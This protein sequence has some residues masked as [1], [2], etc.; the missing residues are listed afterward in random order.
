[1]L[2][3]LVP[4]DL[5]RVRFDDGFWAPRI[6]VNRTATLPIEYE[7]CLKTGRIDAFR[8]GWKPGQP[9]PPHVFWDSDVAKWIEAAA[10]SLATHPDPVLEGR[11]DDVI[12]LIASAQQPDGYLNCHFT[13]VEPDHRWTNLRD[14]HELYCAGHLIEAGVAHF[15]ATGKRSL[16]DVVCR[17]ADH[18]HSVF[19][20]TKGKK[21][22]YPGHEEIELA[23]VKLHAATGNGRYLR[24]AKYFVDERGRKPHYFEIEAERRGE[25][26]ERRRRGTGLPYSYSQAHLP[27]R[28]QREVAGHAVR[29][30]YLYA[31]MADLA[32][33]YADRDLL[34]AC[35]ALWD[36]LTLKHM[37]LTAGIGS[38]ASNEGFTSD[39]DLPN[40]SAYAE[41]CAAIGLV[42]W[43]DRMLRLERDARYA[44]VMETALYNGVLS[45]VSLD[46]A[47]FFY[48][49]PLESTGSHHREDWFG[50]A[51]CPPNIARLLASIG[52]YAYSQEPEAV[53]VHLY[54]QGRASLNVGD[55]NVGITQKTHY[56][57]DGRVRLALSPDRPARFTLALRIPGW[58]RGARL[59][60]NGRSVTPARLLR[61]G[62][63]HLER[64]W[65]SGDIVTLDLPMPVE[66]IEANPAVLQDC[67]RVALRRGPVV[68]CLEQADNGPHPGDFIL[69]RAGKFKV[70][71]RPDLLGGIAVITGKARRRQFAGWSGCLYRH[72]DA[73]RESVPFIAIP[74]CV[75]D[76]R[77]A[78]EM[79]VWLLTE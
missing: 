60:I 9:N 25:P 48:V 32:A 44:D 50:C 52:T 24:L 19:G 42:F 79:A 53:W 78:G 34:A 56:P 10:Y 31:A 54:A 55:V 6:E 28:Q 40:E 65:T 2:P 3:P 75:W 67:G 20:R 73:R 17:Y 33:A 70:R 21:R 38:T 58:C 26:P 57:W 12:A 36:H 22:G 43:A 14:Q 46:G 59:S 51:C 29:A 49:N 23:L 4:A 41:S 74:Y 1:M 64:L 66:R 47:R 45:G 15:R 62:Y 7:Q 63:A 11:L 18:I 61:K 37:Y 77:A 35:R 16:L 76:N 39:Y 72:K 69:P 8:L 27:V 71:F 5:R 13:V 30:M 68:Y